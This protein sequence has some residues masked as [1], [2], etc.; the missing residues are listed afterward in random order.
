MILNWFSQ[1]RRLQ[2]GDE[3]IADYVNYINS[4]E[5]IEGIKVF[6][7]SIGV[8]VDDVGWTTPSVLITRHPTKTP[9]RSPTLFPIVQPTKFPSESPTF[10]P[11]IISTSRPSVSPTLF[12]TNHV[13]AMPS[14]SPL[15][16]TDK[17]GMA[18]NVSNL[19]MLTLF[20]FKRRSNF[21][22]D[23]NYDTYFHRY[24]NL[25]ADCARIKG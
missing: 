18:N 16:P 3:L 4:D 21:C 10:P 2:A 8:S 25:V 14:V 11:Q 24:R 1:R 13:T 9:T 19:C 15:I 17:P 5:S 7:N 23:R 12:P 6:L 22:T 20:S